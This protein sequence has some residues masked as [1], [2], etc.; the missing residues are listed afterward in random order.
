MAKQKCFLK[1][2]LSEL[3]A[4]HA[5]SVVGNTGFPCK[6]KRIYKTWMLS[7]RV[8]YEASLSSFFFSLMDF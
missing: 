4:V 5:R 2:L 8:S 3:S 6:E 7:A 1:K